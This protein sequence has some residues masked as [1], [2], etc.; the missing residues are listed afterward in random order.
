MQKK[1]YWSCRSAGF[2]TDFGCLVKTKSI[3]GTV[4]WKP[5]KFG[6]KL[7]KQKNKKSEQKVSNDRIQKKNK[8]NVSHNSKNKLGLKPACKIILH[9]PLFFFFFFPSLSFFFK[10]F[11]V[12]KEKYKVQDTFRWIQR[13]L[14][15]AYKCTVKVFCGELSPFFLPLI[16][17][18]LL[19][20]GVDTRIENF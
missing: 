18:M 15:S 13:E 20:S 11:L 9:G 2:H 1:S 5:D 6:T 4:N 12:W 10:P 7:N 8:E 14:L 3:S 17:S 16:P 19:F